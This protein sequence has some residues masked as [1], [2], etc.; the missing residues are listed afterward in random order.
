[1][2]EK[3]VKTTGSIKRKKNI[4]DLDESKPIQ[5]GITIT[6]YEIFESC[7]KRAENLI[8]L[9]SSTESIEEITEQHYCDCYRA[10]V[11]LS[12]SALDAFVRK[13]S[14]SEIL[15]KIASKD[16]L[17]PKLASYLKELLNQDKLLDAARNYNLLEKVEEV[18]KVDLETKSLQSEW[19]IESFLE[20]AGY[21]NIYSEVAS[22]ANI[23][24]KNLK[25]DLG[26]FTKRRHTISHSGDFDLNQA[27]PKENI[28]NKTFAEDCLK[29]VKSFAENI[30]KIIQK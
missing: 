13:I 20:M 5:D 22:K 8:S 27:P 15:K 29:T 6:P 2:A 10:A 21:P 25:G 3:D 11:V 7:I 26:K 17:P 12:I 4:V 28:I 14:I 18:I 30:N 24:E 1:M 16:P 9:H 23:N 19:R